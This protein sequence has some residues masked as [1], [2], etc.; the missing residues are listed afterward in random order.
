[1]FL[2]S[3]D[4]WDKNTTEAG[5]PR[6]DGALHLWNFLLNPN[7]DS[8]FSVSLLGHKRCIIVCMSQIFP[9]FIIAQII[10]F[11]CNYLQLQTCNMS[12][13]LLGYSNLSTKP[14]GQGRSIEINIWHWIFF[15]GKCFVA[16]SIKQGLCDF[17]RKNPVEQY[18]T[19]M[20]WNQTPEILYT[21]D[22]FGNNWGGA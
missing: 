9:W 14:Q 7:S 20:K 4:T 15:L 22:L 13:V 8:L 19:G 5:S 3:V 1:M 6:S 18:Y 17:F 11:Y 21:N 12:S 16:S 10:K 2:F